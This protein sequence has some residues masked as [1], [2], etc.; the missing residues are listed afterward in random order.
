MISKGM[1]VIVRKPDH[2]RDGQ[3]GTVESVAPRV[4]YA[5]V[6]FGSDEF[7][8]SFSFDDLEVLEDDF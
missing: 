8:W 2:W 3:E 5:R 4:D 7:P 6:V 1:D